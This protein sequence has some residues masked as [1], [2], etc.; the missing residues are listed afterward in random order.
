MAEQLKSEFSDVDNASNPQFFVDYLAQKWKTDFSRA[1]KARV[2]DLMQL[3]PAH[4]VL[5]VGCA[6][7]IDL[8]PVVKRPGASGLSAGLDFSY[9][10]V[11]DGQNRTANDDKRPAFLNGDSHYLPFASNSFEVCYS[12]KVFQH[13]ANPQQSLSEIVRVT[14]PG[15]HVIIVDP[16]HDLRVID[17]PYRDIT[18]RL[19]QFKRGYTDKWWH[20][21]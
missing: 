13:L 12:D 3:E 15:G 8:D 16:D 19:L 18:R 7:G 17:T 20:C 9:Q 10:M 11:K 21:T 2:R 1:Y 4:S 6:M 5:D 14:K